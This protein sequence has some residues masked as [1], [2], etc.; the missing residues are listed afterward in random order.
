[1]AVV[2]SVVV[3]AD[4]A[5]SR[6]GSLPQKDGV[7]ASMIIGLQLETCESTQRI[8]RTSKSLKL[9]VTESN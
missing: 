2:R 3:L 9:Q 7:M 4:L 5:L 6:A 1:M 8:L